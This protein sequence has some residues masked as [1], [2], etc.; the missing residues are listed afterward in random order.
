MIY[1]YIF[2]KVYL[3]YIKTFNEKEIPHWFAAGIVSVIIVSTIQVLFDS[4]SYFLNPKLI[5]VYTSYNKYLVL[6]LGFLL[7]IYVSM[8][9]RYLEIINS[10]DQLPKNKKKILGYLSVLY[11]LVVFISFFW[12]GALIR[13]S[14]IP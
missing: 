2:Y 1:K 4:Y 7:M 12:L 13:Q 11:I 6:L 14:N 8:K 10:C 5:G 3:F 9:G